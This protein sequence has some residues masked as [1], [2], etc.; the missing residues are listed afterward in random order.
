MMISE[1]VR[2]ALAW[3]REPA[4]GEFCWC[5]TSRGHSLGTC[6]H[7]GQP[8]TKEVISRGEMMMRWKRRPAR[9]TQK[10]KEIQAR[11]QR[12]NRLAMFGNWRYCSSWPDRPDWND[13]RFEDFEEAW[14]LFEASSV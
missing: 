6:H 9:L 12:D 11:V 4:H 8:F 3:L 14:N 13:Y 10:G 2:S 5:G 1:K 7:C